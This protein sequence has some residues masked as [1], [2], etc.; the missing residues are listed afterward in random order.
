MA[1]GTSWQICCNWQTTA[2]HHDLVRGTRVLMLRPVSTAADIR[3]WRQLVTH[4]VTSVFDKF[5]WSL[6]NLTQL[7]TSQV[8]RRKRVDIGRATR[9]ANLLVMSIEMRRHSISSMMYT[10]NKTPPKRIPAARCFAAGWWTAGECRD[11]HNTL[12][13]TSYY[14]NRNH[15]WAT[16]LTL[17]VGCRRCSRM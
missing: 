11:V 12:C 6:F 8:Q 15:W 4:H 10:M 17:K 5:N 2:K 13:L 7:A 16:P 9:A 14:Q 1:S 3:C